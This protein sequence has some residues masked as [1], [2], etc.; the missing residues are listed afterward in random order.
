MKNATQNVSD[1]LNT[2]TREEL[3]TLATNLNV[4]RGKEKKNT[5]ANLAKAINDG[6][7]QVKT[8]ITIFSLPATQTP[9]SSYTRHGRTLFYGKF[10][11]YKAAK[12]VV[13]PLSS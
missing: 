1:A 4:P 3:R 6:Q 2:L 12:T 10:R 9:P 5:L 13:T 11:N 8:V 7:C